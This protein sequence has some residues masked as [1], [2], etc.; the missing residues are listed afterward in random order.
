MTIQ[1]FQK[2]SFQKA[3][4]AAALAAGLGISTY[5]DAAESNAPEAHSDGIGAA[6]TDA[7][8]TTKIKSRFVGD[9]RLERT[10]ISVTTTNGI[11]T[12]TGTAAG[13]E[14]KTVAETLAG[15]VEGVKSVDNEISLAPSTT[16]SAKI[17]RAATKTQRVASDSWITT[18][19][20]S[21]I[22]ADS[23]SK[24]FKVGVTTTHGVVVLDGALGN[25][26]A[27]E[28]VKKV[29]AKVRGVKSV[30]ISAL[31]VVALN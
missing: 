12:L 31:R 22:L 16:T 14:S 26:D 15:S 23:V 3:L 8:I 13:S 9:N 27:I 21:E 2:S 4:F 25:Q 30:D 11:V 17:D 19:V 18:K 29:A 20:K 28:H 24:G 10:D 7:A 5:A 6:V 1:S